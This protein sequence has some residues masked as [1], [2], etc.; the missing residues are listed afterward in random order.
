MDIR[1]KLSVV[2]AGLACALPALAQDPA[3]A[4]G[5][6]FEQANGEMQRRLDTSVEEL[7]ALREVIAAEKG[8]LAAELRQL[9][10]E[11]STVRA[12]YQAQVRLLDRAN[13]DLTNLKTDIKSL[14]DEATYLSNLFSEY[15]AQ[16]R[17]APAHH[18]AAA[19]RE[20]ARGRQARAREQQLEPATGL[21][22]AVELAARVARP[23]VRRARRHAVRG[24]RARRRRAGLEGLVRARRAGGA[25]PVG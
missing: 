11:L 7:N 22:R 17:V 13:L 2:V 19:L 4:S 25:V 18:R 3:E 14:E 1:N 16:L 5:P 21:R 10:A 9:E 6:T 20:A 15:G 8:P 23:A 24:N 12:D